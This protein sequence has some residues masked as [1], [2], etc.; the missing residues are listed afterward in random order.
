MLILSPGDLLDW[1]SNP[2]LLHWQADS[3]PLHQLRSPRNNMLDSAVAGEVVTS[4]GAEISSVS[5]EDRVAREVR[6]V[7]DEAES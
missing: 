4:L 1:G 5:L 3:L 2:H 7:A 6:V